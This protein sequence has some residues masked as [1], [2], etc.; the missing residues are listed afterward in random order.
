[1]KKTSK[2]KIMSIVCALLCCSSMMM[3]TGCGGTK[4]TPEE[5]QAEEQAKKAEARYNNELKQNDYRGGVQRCGV[6][7]S[8]ILNVMENMKANNVTVREDNPNGFWNV[9]GYQDFVS[10]FLTSSII[11]DTQWFN[12]EEI[13]P[14][15]PTKNWESTLSQ[16]KNYKLSFTQVSGEDSP[17]VFMNGV[18]VLR[19][20]KDDY[21]V[22]GVPFKMYLNDVRDMTYEGTMSIRVLYDC[23]KDWCK[24][25][26]RVYDEEIGA[27]ITPQLFEFMRIDNDTFAIQ[28]E[29]E[30]LLIK[31]KSVDGDVDIREREISE[32][33]YSKLVNDGMRTTF[34]PYVPLPEYDE[35][36]MVDLKENQEKNKIM[37]EKVW[38]NENGDIAT[39]YGESNSVFYRSPFEITE[40][41]FVFEDKALQQA[42]CYKDGVLVAT[43]YNK[44]STEYEQ[45]TYSLA[46]AD[47]SIITELE[48]KVQIKNLI[49][50]SVP[51]DNEF[52][53]A[54]E[55]KVE[56]T[57]IA[58]DK[59]SE[60]VETVT[61][62]TTNAQSAQDIG[63][64]ETTTTET[65]GNAENV[66][67]TAIETSNAENVETTVAE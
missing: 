6:L 66:E 30:R 7:K 8:E 63:N 64:A 19:R 45:F 40:D 20:E 24:A 4:Q 50:S 9:D 55:D 10:T 53:K 1:M 28:T 32:F 49:G 61:T 17:Y 35:M 22:T 62:T 41:N 39:S 67:T 60:I 26:G 43:T 2:R 36:T 42:I 57:T 58:E 48:N 11:N 5:I 51:I 18:E 21:S 27:T 38:T 12:E 3:F 34:T 47:K 25:Y 52:K 29:T 23:D 65:T 31:L 15:D 33:Y 56:E 59:S 16:M 37:A 44:L 14:D 13:A 54:E 46:S